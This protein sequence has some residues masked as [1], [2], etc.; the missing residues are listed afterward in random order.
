M[1]EMTTNPALKETDY[2]AYGRSISEDLAKLYQDQNGSVIDRI[3]NSVTLKLKDNRPNIDSWT[4]SLGKK[5]QQPATVNVSIKTTD[6]HVITWNLDTVI[7]EI[8]ATGTLP[9]QYLPHLQLLYNAVSGELNSTL[10]D[11]ESTKPSASRN[12]FTLLT[13]SENLLNLLS[14]SDKPSVKDYI[15]RTR[16]ELDTL[17]TMLKAKSR[18]MTRR[19]MLKVLAISTGLTA[20]AVATGAALKKQKIQAPS[21]SKEDMF[22]TTAPLPRPTEMPV[23]DSSIKTVAP[24]PQ[25]TIVPTEIPADQEIGDRNVAEFFLDKFFSLLRDETSQRLAKDAKARERVD[26]ELEQNGSINILLLGIDQA[27]WRTEN[28][29]WEL[30]GQYGVG[31]NDVSIVLSINPKTL[32]TKIVSFPRDLYSPRVQQFINENTH[33]DNPFV[34]PLKINGI[35]PATRINGITC[36][37]MIEKRPD[38]TPA[39]T[40]MSVEEFEKAKDLLEP[41]NYSKD[42]L[43]TVMTPEDQVELAREEFETATGLPLHAAF[44]FNIDFTEELFSD[45]CSSGLM[46]P[47]EKDIDIRY[48]YGDQSK[49]YHFQKTPDGAEGTLLKGDELVAY[50]RT[51][52]D[53]GGSDDTRGN[54][55]RQVVQAFVKNVASRLIADLREGKTETLDLIIHTLDNQEKERNNLWSSFNLTPVLT[56]VVRSIENIL[57][58]PNSLSIFSTL[59]LNTLPHLSAD[60]FQSFGIPQELW[61]NV[62]N[63]SIKVINGSTEQ[64]PPEASSKGNFLSYWQPVRTFVK[65]TVFA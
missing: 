9:S 57:K 61:H 4:L 20:G 3:N 31:N 27:R 17:R 36:K 63:R 51:R 34:D 55:E 12:S 24:N 44:K 33:G 48:L 10:E 22:D 28:R 7:S 45:L 2:Q 62:D 29:E 65:D 5:N 23:V 18:L 56:K 50:A 16:P 21:I 13:L 49:V 19:K 11:I 37:R 8:Q 46:V 25:P 64:P 59:A 58:Q 38:G 14:A 52:K 54:R 40:H 32:K 6:Q 47:I 53:I 43:P 41:L 42:N 35:L 30:L 60:M 39:Q 15:A 26:K 1:N